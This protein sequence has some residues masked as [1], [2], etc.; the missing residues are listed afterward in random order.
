MQLLRRYLLLMCFWLVAD[1]SAMGSSS[2]PSVVP[3]PSTTPNAQVSAFP[4]GL[5]CDSTCNASELAKV[6]LIAAKMNETL[7]SDCFHNFFLASQ[8]V[9]NSKGLSR[10]QIV[11]KLRE[12]SSLTLNY[13]YNRW[14]RA[15]GYESA[16]DFG[17]IHF[18]R[19]K[20]GSFSACQLA[21]LAAHEMSHSKGFFHNGNSPGPNRFTV[22]YLINTAFEEGGCCR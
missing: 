17:V 9:D 18:N 21:S 11:S 13:Y 20:L 4:V 2:A 8:R 22:P 6:P 19:A 15:L 14:T 1:A 16:N 7:L 5:K 3:S 12:P 10:E